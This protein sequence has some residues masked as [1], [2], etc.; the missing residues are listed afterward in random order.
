MVFDDLFTTVAYMKKSEVPPNWTELVSKSSEQ[1]TDKDYNLAKTW[2]FP[3]AKS[4]DIAMQTNKQKSIIPIGINDVAPNALST[5][6]S[7][8]PRSVHQLPQVD[9]SGSNNSV[10]G[11]SIDS[12]RG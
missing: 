1:V 8:A 6:T 7:T 11:I 5:N 9:F 12:I 4:G 2:L 10:H 3:D